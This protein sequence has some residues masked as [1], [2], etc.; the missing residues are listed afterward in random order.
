M[1]FYIVENNAMCLVIGV[2]Y[3]D[4]KQPINFTIVAI[5]AERISNRQIIVQQMQCYSRELVCIYVYVC[6][7]SRLS[8]MDFTLN[9]TADC[10]V[11]FIISIYSAV[12]FTYPIAGKSLNLR[13]N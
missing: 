2:L 6:K 11:S 7:N 1:C 4:L 10:A 12:S 3:T 8:I 9:H 5:I 13:G